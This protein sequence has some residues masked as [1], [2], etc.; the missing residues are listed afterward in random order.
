LKKQRRESFAANMLVQMRQVN[1]V[2]C[3]RA[4]AASV[5]NSA[6]GGEG[7]RGG[8]KD[9]ALARYM[10][11]RPRCM[12]V[13]LLMRQSALATRAREKGRRPVECRNLRSE[14]WM[15]VAKRAIARKIDVVI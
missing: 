8:L 6:G 2:P 12:A 14:K 13:V 11:V 10:S 5:T 4:L 3:W 9:S 1:A 7:I 15:M